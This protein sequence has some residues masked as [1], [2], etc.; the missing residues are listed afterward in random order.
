[1]K[2]LI[3]GANGYIGSKLL[4]LLAEKGYEVV[5]LVRDKMRLH[6]EEKI[7]AKITILEIDLLHLSP[8]MVVPQD[9]DVAYY[10]IH[11]MSHP[12]KDFAVLDK[13]IAENF[14][15]L[16]NKTSC[17]QIIYLSGL[18]DYSPSKH[19]ASRI[20]VESILR[21]AN[22]PLTTLRAAIIIGSGSA[23]FEIMRDLVE[24][25]PIMIAPKW[26]KSLCQPIA[27]RDVLNY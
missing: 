21:G 8:S 7:L 14:L 26:I 27:V 15:Q 12:T 9:I 17:K 19:L 18:Q 22:A 24:K 16:I 4:P 20:E 5:A 13:N 6:L 11:S 3:T 23:S 1:M 25:L 10:F 2:I